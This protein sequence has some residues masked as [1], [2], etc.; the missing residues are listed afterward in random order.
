MAIAQNDS[1]AK[2]ASINPALLGWYKVVESSNDKIWSNGGNIC[3][4]STANAYEIL[5]TGFSNNGAKVIGTVREN[6]INIPQQTASIIPFGGDGKAIWNIQTQ[7]KGTLKSGTIKL[8]FELKRDTLPTFKGEIVAV[9]FPGQ[10][11][12]I[13]HIFYGWV[14][15]DLNRNPYEIG[16]F[17]KNGIKN[18]NWLYRDQQRRLTADVHYLNDTLNGWAIYYYHHNDPEVVKLE[19]MILK[20]KKVGEWTHKVRK[21]RSSSWKTEAIYMYDYK[22]QL[23]SKTFT[24]PNGKPKTQIFYSETG[25]EIWYRFYTKDGKIYKDDNIYPWIEILIEK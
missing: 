15:Y 20:G 25:A 10:D 9:R 4:S 24:Y 2:T 19:G 12:T 11:T 17:Y 5:F 3:I 21:N 18:G 13:N 22:E 8:F 7:A 16:Q 6:K 14:K 23:I 1:I